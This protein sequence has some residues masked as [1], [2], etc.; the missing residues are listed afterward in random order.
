VRPPT[1]T[2]RPGIRR[3][4]PPPPPPPPGSR[5][6]FGALAGF[7]LAII[8]ACWTE[9]PP[10]VPDEPPPM[11]IGLRPAANVQAQDAVTISFSAPITLASEGWPIT[12]ETPDHRVLPVGVSMTSGG[13]ELWLAPIEGWPPGQRI[14]VELHAGFVDRAGRPLLLPAES[15]AFETAIEEVEPNQIAIRYP[16][17][18]PPAPLNLRWLALSASN[19][20]MLPQEV[21]LERDLQRIVAPVERT[22]EGGVFLARLPEHRGVCDPL[23]PGTRYVIEGVRGEVVTATIADAIPP[24]LTSTR[25]VIR[26]DRVILEVE[27]SE[28]VLLS[29]RL[30]APDGTETAIALPLIASR[31]VFVA[32]DTK[33][34]SSGGEYLIV[35]E[36]EDIAGNALEPFAV[37]FRAPTLVAAQ[38]TE[39]VPAPIHDWNDSD[40]TGVAFDAYPGSGPVTDSDEWIEIVNTSSFAIDLA[41]A[42]LSVRTLDTSPTET[43][44]DGVAHL[45]FGYGG[46]RAAWQPG[47]ALVFRPRGSISQRAFTIELHSGTRR[48]D[49]VI[50][51]DVSGADAN[52]GTPPDLDH[53]ALARDP[54]GV[55][56]WC[57]PT[58]GDPLPAQDC[59]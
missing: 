45:Y 49:S 51:G 35:T 3:P 19:R 46:S 50:V 42:G 28:P 56:R 1:I 10:A 38:I 9:Q 30:V 41:A 52:E 2:R 11:L 31:S 40:K 34:L 7:A 47:E 8:S 53:E 27:A 21:V 54:S 18:A 57:R 37:G 25:V 59:R 29:A 44:L 55:F 12:V 13:K 33:I 32:P 15:P 58:P 4:P 48:L 14:R 20:E 23:C 43:V 36:V 6:Q 5:W 22:T 17:V 16:P 39:V 26:G 24:V